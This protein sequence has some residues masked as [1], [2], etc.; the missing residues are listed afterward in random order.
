M[1]NL[2]E[3]VNTLLNIYK[4]YLSYDFYAKR[5][6]LRFSNKQFLF[7]HF[8]LIG[9]RKGISP[10]PLFDSNWYSR[11]YKTENLTPF[12]HY[13]KRGWKLENDPHPLFSISHYLKTNR[14]VAI[15][16]IEPLRHYLRYGF[17]ENRPIS[18]WFLPS[19]AEEIY[20][21]SGNRYQILELLFDP[22]NLGLL[23]GN[24][25]SISPVDHL[26][27]VKYTNS[28]RLDRID[29]EVKRRFSIE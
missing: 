24:S 21:F 15:N 2:K 22:D 10:N 14:D 23:P 7:F 28:K 29:D 12:F 27:M 9:S 19:E 8:C 5:A 4:D 6:S 18:D 26:K 20:G 17:R 16:G 3:R 1:K 11:T 13:I 25:S